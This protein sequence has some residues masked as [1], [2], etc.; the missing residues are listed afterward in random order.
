[1][2]HLTQI[3]RKRFLPS[4]T[5]THYTEHF[6]CSSSY[7]AVWEGMYGSCVSVL[8]VFLVVLAIQTRHI[9]YSNFKDTKKINVFVFVVCMMLTTLLPLSQFL[10]VDLPLPSYIM[11][12]L[13]TLVIPASCLLLQYLPKLFPLIAQQT[14]SH[15][16]SSHAF[17][18]N[19]SA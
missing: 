1:M 11:K 9:K 14:H 7:L 17:K 2:D 15:L 8:M 16:S 10:Q 12:S 4:N 5:D 19:I 3:S 18:A 13:L 6:Y